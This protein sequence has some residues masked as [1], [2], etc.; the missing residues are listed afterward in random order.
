MNKKIEKI[1]DEIS[2]FINEENGNI[3]E[4]M[5]EYDSIEEV[6]RHVSK[7]YNVEIKLRYIGGFDSP[8][9]DVDCYAW[10]SIID[11]DLYFDSLQQERY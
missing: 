7:K 6:I 3:I 5:Y 10:A 2:S 9:Y 8:G 11:G 1:H 4:N